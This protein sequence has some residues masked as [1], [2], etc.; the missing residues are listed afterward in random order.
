[1]SRRKR[2]KQAKGPLG[3]KWNSKLKSDFKKLTFR[4]VVNPL[5]TRRGAQRI[6]ANQINFSIRMKQTPARKK[7]IEDLRR[8]YN[9]F[10]AG[11]TVKNTSIL[12][13]KWDPKLK[14]DYKFLMVK[15]RINPLMTNSGAQQKILEKLF[16]LKN[17]NETSRGFIN[18]PNSAFKSL[19]SA[20][21]IKSKNRLRIKENT[22][23][24]EA[25]NKLFIKLGK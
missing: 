23:R 4:K 6:L 1:M 13:M 5:M 22:K 20:R 7:R 25:L 18:S 21:E 12:G 2:A 24:I 9:R 10:Q 14:S 19:K 17:A 8:L 15:D 3:I 11:K 16:F